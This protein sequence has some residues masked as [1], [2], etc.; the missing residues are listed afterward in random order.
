MDNFTHKQTHTVTNNTDNTHKYTYHHINTVWECVWMMA[1]LSS[2]TWPEA[3]RL[4]SGA[5]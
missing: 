4:D 3:D 5:G 2:L 1:G